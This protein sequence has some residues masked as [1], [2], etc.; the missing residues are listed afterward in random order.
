MESTEAA[1][2]VCIAILL[3]P[4]AARFLN[5]CDYD[6]SA[7]QNLFRNILR[8]FTS[9]MARPLP[10]PPGPLTLEIK[11]SHEG[12]PPVT[13]RIEVSVEKLDEILLLFG[14]KLKPDQ[15]WILD[16]D[17][18]VYLHEP[19]RQ[20]L[21]AHCISGKLTIRPEGAIPIV[22]SLAYSEVIQDFFTCRATDQEPLP[23][24][25]LIRLGFVEANSR[26]GTLGL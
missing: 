3:S 16:V 25:L 5:G 1:L 21:A 24:E 20:T 12:H 17:S 9:S 2:R 13:E 26:E 6:R 4:R 11:E 15:N 8:L 22:K 18:L 7:P 23:E 19:L 10:P 14:L